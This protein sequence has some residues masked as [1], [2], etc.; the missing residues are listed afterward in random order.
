MRS[1]ALTA[2]LLASVTLCSC[3]DEHDGFRPKETGLPT[4]LPFALTRPDAGEPLAEADI[5]AFTVRLTGLWKQID[6]FRWVVE[7]CHGM[8]A[9]TGYPDYLIW[10][11]DVDAVKE[12]DTVT[13]RHNPEYGGSHNNAEPTSLVLTQAIGAYLLTGDEAAGEVVEQFAKSFTAVMKGFVYDDDDPLPYLM[14]RNIVTHNHAFELP[15]GKRKAVDYEPWYTTYEGWNA[16]RVHFPDNPTWGDIYVTTMR[17]KDDVPFMYRATAWFPYLLE[18]AEDEDLQAAVSEALEHMQGFAKDIV[19]SG[20][21]IRTKDAQG[22]PFVPDE[23][24][25]SF[26]S[27]LDLFPDAECD[28]RLS[29]ALLATGQPLGNECGSGQG[30]PYDTIAGGLHNYNYSIIDTYHLAALQL[31]LIQRHDAMAEALLRGYL[32][33]LERY[34]DPDGGEPGWDDDRWERDIALLLLK[35]ASLGLPLTSAE[36]RQ[37]HR[38]HLQA[39]EAYETFAHWDL[40]DDSVPEGTYDFR[41]GFHP[42]HSPDAIRI[43]DI[44]FVLEYCWSPFRNEAGVRFVDCDIVADPSRW[45]EG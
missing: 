33:R 6:Y 14:A 24:L 28:A 35:G 7:T 16:D 30:S 18:H 3:A 8:D 27:Y 1:A 45:G 20:Y 41:A 31:A 13:F 34:Q 23:D 32:T 15:S 43:E 11:H 5:T 38:F 26:V 2:V 37:V 9:S 10:W 44:A 36:A 21:T 40:W 39:V 42:A 22:Q 19:D 29:S 4:A 12:G 25:A 17:S